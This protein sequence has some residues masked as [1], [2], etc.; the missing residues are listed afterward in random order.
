MKG[1]TKVLITVLAMLALAV[2]GFNAIGLAGQT[3][4]QIDI[5]GPCDEVEHANDLQ[6][7]D[8]PAVNPSPEDSPSPDDSPS[9]GGGVD[10]SGPGNG[11]DDDNSNSG[12]GDGDDDDDD[13][14]NSG[15]GGG[16]DDNSGPGSDD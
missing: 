6:C 2:V 4:P 10:N 8:A 12:P 11:G 3:S 13:D 15:P 9:P 5:S 1:K 16:D 7:T 14:D